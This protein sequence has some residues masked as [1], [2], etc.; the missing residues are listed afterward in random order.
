MSGVVASREYF[1]G[2][3]MAELLSAGFLRL[4]HC[5][6]DSIA[7]PARSDPDWRLKIAFEAYQMADAMIDMQHARVTA[8]QD[9]TP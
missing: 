9:E 8:T 5:E 3:A 2:L 6:H 4:L 1:A 7:E